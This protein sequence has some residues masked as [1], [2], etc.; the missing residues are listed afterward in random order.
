MSYLVNVKTGKIVAYTNKELQSGE[1]VLLSSERREV[2]MCASRKWSLV[3]A[4]EC[5]AINV[6]IW[7]GVGVDYCIELNK[8]EFYI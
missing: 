6:K 7:G 1:R 2:E 5:E 3:N 8:N 4:V